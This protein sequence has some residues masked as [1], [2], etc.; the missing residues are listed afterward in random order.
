MT[1][2]CSVLKCENKGKECRW[3]GCVYCPDHWKDHRYLSITGGIR[4]CC[5]G[6]GKHDKCH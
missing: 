5:Q 1:K 4:K 2:R 3:C 6:Y